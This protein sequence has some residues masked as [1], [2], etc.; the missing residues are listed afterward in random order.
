MAKQLRFQILDDNG[1]VK[2]TTDNVLTATRAQL[3]GCKV[4]DTQAQSEEE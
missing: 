1:N 3:A 4:V 2:F